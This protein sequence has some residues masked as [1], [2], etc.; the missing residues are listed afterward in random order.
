MPLQTTFL[1]EPSYS[2]ADWHESIM[3]PRSD[4]LSPDRSSCTT[5]VTVPYE[6]YKAA[7]RFILGFQWTD[8]SNNLRRSTPVFNPVYP[9]LYASAITGTEFKGPDDSKRYTPPFDFSVYAGGYTHVEVTVEFRERLYNLWQDWEVETEDERWTY[10]TR[11]PYTELV[12]I[13]GGTLLAHAPSVPGITGNPYL[14]APHVLA[15]QSKA[16]ILLQWFQVPTDFVEDEDGYSSKFQAAEKCVN[17]A[18]FWGRRAGTLLLEHVHLDKKPAPIT[19]DL[20][21]GLHW[22]YDITFELLE[23]NPPRGDTS[24]DKYG[25]NLLPGPSSSG[26][27]GPRSFKYYFY[28]DDGTLTGKPLFDSYSFAKLFTHHSL[29]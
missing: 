28:T 9:W 20:L 23:F 6:K 10:Q 27:S 5:V 4:V 25:H 12:Q 7:V 26:A 1:F 8:E 24:I 29:T 2:E 17:D 11:E 21:E 18:T 16:K 13:D 19:T 15:K 22:T 3:N 14:A